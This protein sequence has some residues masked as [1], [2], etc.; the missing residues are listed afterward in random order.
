MKPVNLTIEAF[1][2]YKNKVFIDFTTIEKHQLFVISGPTGAGKTTIFDAICFALYGSASGSDRENNDMLRSNYAADDVSTRVDFTFDLKGKRY[3]IFRQ[4]GHIR[5]G[6]KTKTG[7]K[8]GF[9]EIKDEQQ[10]PCVERQIVSEIDARVVELI[11]LTEKQFKQI[12]MLPQGE[13]RK[14]LISETKN[15][16]EILRSLFETEK[17]NVLN[18]LLNEKRKSKARDFEQFEIRLSQTYEDLKR[19]LEN[20][21]ESETVKLLN[22]TH[23]LMK[24]VA[25]ALETDIQYIQTSLGQY[26]ERLEK[27]RQ[28]SR[29]MA[30]DYQEKT[31]VNAQFEQLETHLNQLKDLKNESDLWQRKVAQ[32]KLAEKIKTVQP[33][34]ESMQ[35]TQ[36]KVTNIQAGVKLTRARLKT[37]KDDLLHTE[38]SYQGLKNQE[39]ERDQLKIEIDAQK[40]WL[41]IVE[42]S[43]Q[44]LK[45]VQASKEAV[46]KLS[47]SRASLK[48][49]YEKSQQEILRLKDIIL[50]DEA[51][52][53]KD[54]NIN[55]ALQKARDQYRLLK[56]YKDYCDR[57]AAAAQ[58][59]TE[60]TN[61]YKNV[62]SE[63]E[64]MEKIWQENHAYQLALALKDNQPCP[65]CGSPHHPE[66]ANTQHVE[67]LSDDNRRILTER[68]DQAYQNLAKAQADMKA[69]EPLLQESKH[70]LQREGFDLEHLQ[71]Q[72]N[73][74][75][76]KGRRLKQGQENH[77]ALKKKNQT[78][79]AKLKD[80]ESKLSKIE[81]E[82]AH[83]EKELNQENQ[84][85][86]SLKTAYETE[87]KAIPEALRTV[88][89]LKKSIE[90]LEDKSKA[91][92]SAWEAIQSKIEQNKNALRDL[93]NTLK[94][95]ADQ[96]ES[97]KAEYKAQGEVFYHKLA[98]IGLDS[99][100]LYQEKQMS[101]DQIEVLRRDIEG[102]EE[103]VKRHEHLIA[104]LKLAL[105]SKVPVDL[106]QLKVAVDQA[107]EKAD[108]AYQAYHKIEV[109][110]NNLQARREEFLKQVEISAELE[111]SLATIN[112][113]YQVMHGDN[114][115]KISFERFIQIDYLEMIIEAANQRFK[116]LSEGKFTLVRSENLE[117]RGKQS[118]LSIDV[119]DSH[120]GMTRDVKSLSGGEK[121]LASLCLAL[122]LSD[123]IQSYQGG[124]S[125]NMMFIDEG[126]G[127]LDEEALF[128]AIEAL[129]Q[130]KE[131]GRYIGVI[132]H[133]EELKNIFPVQLNVSKNPEGI[134]QAKF[135]VK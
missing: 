48:A 30:E 29:K 133:V 102:Y 22:E 33:Y 128:K 9:Y 75:L 112:H 83:I 68:K 17:Y 73:D 53:L 105:E 89:E 25:D 79:K 109:L 96:A 21:T 60:M 126:F 1:G 26:G 110:K 36:Q 28:L 98:A 114:P 66:K 127:T 50:K 62:Y 132:S 93:E 37:A 18:H 117:M 115:K 23:F 131:S 56:T 135:I 4:L 19:L 85:Y 123:V 124:I 116:V 55:D 24:D 63:Y 72:M 129:V 97:L 49:A 40:K 57:Q 2:S 104:E 54:E 87:I 15:K 5:H 35:L 78:D 3:Y 11:G 44:M 32:L 122:G 118:G 12:V 38:K 94:F 20:Q 86:I 65:V 71:S 101:D 130:L 107:A 125:I 82:K 92:T 13:F 67:T 6:N 99:I 46:A 39:T 81:A 14:L 108:E 7:D 121:F 95:Q 27:Q 52:L 106:T 90:K 91:M 59:Q 45:K 31:R 120:T 61:S 74:M 100:E 69:L 51:K 42:N 64:W 77:Q 134:S 34:E 103:A 76:T 111:Q 47:Q 10:V 8:Y 16:E 88:S 58:R 113:V 80:E 119:Y 43:E 41:S 70:D 84:A